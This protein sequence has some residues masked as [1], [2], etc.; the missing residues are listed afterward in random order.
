MLALLSLCEVIS[1]SFCF[2]TAFWDYLPKVLRLM[3]H[4]SSI[5]AVNG[6]HHLTLEQKKPTS[7]NLLFFDIPVLRR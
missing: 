6:Q 3:L 5:L 7:V 4:A 1:V 2:V